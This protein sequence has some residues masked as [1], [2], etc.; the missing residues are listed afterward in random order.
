MAD[1]GNGTDVQ[2]GLTNP[3]RIA[4]W[5][6]TK[7][8]A[9]DRIHSIKLLC[10]QSSPATATCLVDVAEDYA[11]MLAAELNG[12]IFGFTMVVAAVA[13]P[14]AF[15]CQSRPKI[16]GHCSCRPGEDGSG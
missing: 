11:N 2:A 16:P 15:A 1:R 4:A 12:Q 5:V 10:E 13:V 6:R 8:S 3:S 9:P 14:P 7:A